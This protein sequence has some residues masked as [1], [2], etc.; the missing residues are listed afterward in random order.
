MC[1]GYHLYMPEI[2]TV[3][4]VVELDMEAVLLKGPGETLESELLLSE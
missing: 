3:G 4:K 2:N 1:L